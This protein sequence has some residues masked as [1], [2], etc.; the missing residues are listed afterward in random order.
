LQ[1]QKE[2]WVGNNF[3]VSPFNY[4]PRVVAH[5]KF[6]SKISIH[7]VT[8][9]D[10]EQTPGVVL[11][12]EE[13]VQIAKVLDEVGL[14]R[15]EAG[16]PVV[17][18]EDFQAV[19][20]IA[21]LGLSATVFAF[22]RLNKED[23]DKAIRADVSGIVCEGPVGVPKLKQFAWSYEQVIERAVEAVS[24][25]KAHGL[26]TVFFGV[27]TTRADLSF[28]K[29]LYK[30]LQ[31]Q[32]KP[33]AIAIVDTFGCASPEGFGYLVNEARKIVSVPVEVHTHDDFGLGVATAIA[34]LAN[35]AEV[36]HTSVNG[37]G[38]RC[39]N[40]SFEELALS[41]NLLY[42]VDL[43]F[44][45]SRFS[46]L[47]QL[48]QR[49]T[50]IPIPPNKPLVGE[51]A[52]TRESGISVAGWIKYN[53]GSEAYLPEVVGNKHEILVGKKSGRHSIE[54]KLAQLGYKAKEKE[55]EEILKVVKQKAEE[56]KT[57]LDDTEF[58]RIVERVISKPSLIE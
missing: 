3:W 1:P 50:Q 43:P 49:F 40:A 19:K 51:R 7:D 23:I 35:G 4:E 30:T 31:E 17:S 38:E 21:H 32:A 55:V 26:Y 8:L 15:I 56:K 2:K 36:A 57:N 34:G 10:G 18:E 54:W 58:T 28:L 14:H 20:T 5:A 33:D 47:S 25:A 27:D 6:P 22:S 53:L 45:F 16:M 52:F 11:R 41:L 37:I 9:R 13:K 44:N 24:Y 46:E 12:K 48:V 29:K 42:G 39:G